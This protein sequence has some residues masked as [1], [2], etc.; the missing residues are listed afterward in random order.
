MHVVCLVKFWFQTQ[1]FASSRHGILFLLSS[2]EKC[3]SFLIGVMCAACRLTHSSTSGHLHTSVRIDSPDHVTCSFN[4]SFVA[5]EHGILACC[6]PAACVELIDWRPC[7]H[8]YC[9]ADLVFNAITM[10]VPPHI[11]KRKRRT[12]A[13]EDLYNGVRPVLSARFLLQPYPTATTFTQF[14]QS[15]DRAT[16]KSCPTSIHHVHWLSRG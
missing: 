6:L 13:P 16:A 15:R 2:D 9:F 1:L 10:F 5:F 14:F 12:P 8:Q 11:P 4:P 3:K 7:R